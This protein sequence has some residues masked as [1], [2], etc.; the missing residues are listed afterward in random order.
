MN[1]SLKWTSWHLIAG[2]KTEFSK[3]AL[4]I[5]GHNGTSSFG[6][7]NFEDWS[8]K[9]FIHIMPVSGKVFSPVPSSF[10]ALL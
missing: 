5:K 7:L 1:P 4:I 9:R 3:W 8:L 10:F 6:M 2:N